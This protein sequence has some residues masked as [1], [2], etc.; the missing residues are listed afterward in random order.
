ME[1]Q[2]E[3]IVRLQAKGKGPAYILSALGHGDSYGAKYAKA[4]IAKMLSTGLSAH[5]VIYGQRN[6][7]S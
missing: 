6:V 5:E 1:T 4:V 3:F 7:W 2:N